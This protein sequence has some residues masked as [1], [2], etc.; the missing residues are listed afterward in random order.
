MKPPLGG[1]LSLSHTQGS[2]NSIHKKNIPV[3]SEIIRIII[4]QVPEKP[5]PKLKM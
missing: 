5:Y 2:C 4:K 1:H 3:V